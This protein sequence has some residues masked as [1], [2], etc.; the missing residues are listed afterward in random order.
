[1]DQCV[2]STQ[3]TKSVAAIILVTKGLAHQSV[4][5]F[6]TEPGMENTESYSFYYSTFVTL[7]RV[8]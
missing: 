2:Q 6:V 5:M 1:M 3:A 7:N 4:Q 8:D